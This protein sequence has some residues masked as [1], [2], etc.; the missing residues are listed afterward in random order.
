M[1]S[2]ATNLGPSNPELE[3]LARERLDRFLAENPGVTADQVPVEMVTASASGLD[4]DVS[5][6]SALLQVPRVARETGIPE[7][8]LAAMVHVKVEGRFLGLFG[9]PRVNVLE[10]NL[11]VLRM[12]EEERP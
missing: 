11:E 12:Q 10:L 7:G 6:E 5:E 1:L 9:Q 8:E 2:G 4:P 3:A